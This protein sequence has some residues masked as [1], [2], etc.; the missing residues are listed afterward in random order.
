M[1]SI[2]PVCSSERPT[3]SKR[4]SVTPTTAFIGFL[5]RIGKKEKESRV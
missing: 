2:Y 1:T 3:V 4:I 5:R